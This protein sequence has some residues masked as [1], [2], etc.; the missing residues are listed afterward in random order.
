MSGQKIIRWLHMV[1]W[2]LCE[3]YR[4]TGCEEIHTRKYGL[5][6]RECKRGHRDGS[7]SAVPLQVSLP[8]EKWKK[9]RQKKIKPRVPAETWP[10]V[11]GCWN[12]PLW[13][14]EPSSRMF[15][16]KT[17]WE[18]CE[19]M[20]LPLPLFFQGQKLTW[21]KLSDTVGHPDLEAAQRALA[22]SECVLLEPMCWTHIFSE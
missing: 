17:D 21:Q 9:G 11:L 13:R 5:W 22:D 16:G 12:I 20:A 4:H 3:N 7:G 8:G 19:L 18:K 10:S 15:R 14:H 2:F 1:W 6:L